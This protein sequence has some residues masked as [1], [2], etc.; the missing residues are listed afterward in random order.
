MIQL[1]L[2]KDGRLLPHRYSLAGSNVI[3][4]ISARLALASQ[5]PR[6]GL[7]ANWAR[8]AVAK[9]IAMITSK[10]GIHEPVAW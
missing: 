1:R 10:T 9:F 4:A 7:R 3:A 2:G 5:R 8:M 6:I